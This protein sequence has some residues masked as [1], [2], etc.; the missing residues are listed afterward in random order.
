MAKSD[1]IVTNVLLG[2]IVVVLIVISVM[3]VSKK[4]EGFYNKPQIAAT[5]LNPIN[6]KCALTSTG[7]NC[8]SVRARWESYQPV[9]YFS[10]PGQNCGYMIMDSNPV[11][12]GNNLCCNTVPGSALG[13]K[14]GTCDSSKS[15]IKF[16]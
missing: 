11:K 15:T 5:R 7:S 16:S 10:G 14:C 13:G 2:V 4:N 1:M 9:N 3:C 12:C 8:P 6:L